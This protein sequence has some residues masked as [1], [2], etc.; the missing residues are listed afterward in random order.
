MIKTTFDSSFDL[1]ASIPKGAKVGILGCSSCAS[2]YRTGDTEKIQEVRELLE[3]H[4]EVV[5]ST[6]VDSPCDQRVLRYLAK[7]FPQFDSIE[8]FVVLACEA[9]TRSL[10][11]L[12]SAKVISPLRTESFSIRSLDGKSKQAC[13]FCD[14]CNFP[15]K[16]CQC[17]VAS[18]PIHKTDGPCQSRTSDRCVAD[19]EQECIWLSAPVTAPSSPNH[20][21][22]SDVSL[23]FPAFLVSSP[24]SLKDLKQL[25][26]FVLKQNISTLFVS[27]SENGISP[28]VVIGAIKDKVEGLS[29]GL[30]LN[31]G[32]K[33]GRALATDLIT[34]SAL[35]V[36][37]IFIKDPVNPTPGRMSYD[38]SIELIELIKS[39][40][41]SLSIIV[42]N[43]FLHQSDLFLLDTQLEAGAS[44]VVSP[45]F[46]GYMEHKAR[47][48]KDILVH[49]CPLAEGEKLEGDLSNKIVDL[50][51]LVGE[52]LFKIG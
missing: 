43:S 30:C 17:P 21:K 14:E 22:A 47:D 40:A 29:L 38:S 24:G 32:D 48:Y 33:K 12:V 2:V 39:E 41:S 20:P 50:T 42:E 45:L 35:G 52:A 11:G 44:L 15:D 37:Y 7:T 34:A 49:A 3:D 8:V 4:C 31:G 46:N 27:P 6:S 10:G 18:C 26:D 23:S 36:E 13:L 25:T 28:L 5:L 19:K 16:S 51:S 1:K 9:G